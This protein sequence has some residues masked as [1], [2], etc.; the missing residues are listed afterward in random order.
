MELPGLA[1]ELYGMTKQEAIRAGV[2]I[3]CKKNAKWYSPAGKQEYFISGLCEYCFDKITGEPM[4][5]QRN[6]S[7]VAGTINND[8]ALGCTEDFGHDTGYAKDG[9]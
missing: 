9:R 5:E 3:D 8:H 6:G 2:C 7:D 4:V 1:K